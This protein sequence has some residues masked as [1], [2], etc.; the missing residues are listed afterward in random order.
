M[1]KKLKK[2]LIELI[3]IF[4]IVV[5]C[6]LNYTLFFNIINY[7]VKLTMPLIIGLSLAFIVN[8][9]MKAIE[10]KWFKV[11]KRKNKKLIRVLSLIISLILIFGI[12]SL[13]LF[14]VVPEV[15]DAVTSILKS[16]Y[17]IDWNHGIASKIENIYP[18]AKTY[19]KNINLENMVN[20][21]FGSPKDI[22][23][24]IVTFVTG[25]ASKIFMFFMGLIISIYI[26]V[27]K[28]N[29]ITT[30]KKVLY[31]FVK[32]KEAKEIENVFS[33]ANK[34]FSNFITGQCLDAL[35]TG[36]ELFIVLWLVRIP[37][38]LIIGVLFSVTALIPYIG[39]F[40]T[41]IIG[42]LLVAVV[43]PIYA[44]WYF[45]IY[46][47]IQQ[48]DNNYTYPKIVGNAVGLPP[49]LALVA[50][51]IGGSISGF[52]GMIISIPLASVLYTLF[53]DYINK[54]LENKKKK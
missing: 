19:I 4:G 52:I 54:R 50:V 39:G 25:M 21:T 47:I 45:I 28:E 30:T 18:N 22:V 31:A 13:I 20:T 6:V 16:I 8:V 10:E 44:L 53:K 42:A 41:L 49:L 40:I 17:N 48:F 35:L 36:F 51:L 43:N 32:E 11:N 23:N 33:L 37:Y 24:T 29:L 46:T 9:P 26:L 2:E 5:W 14:L 12:L 3:I 38:A 7:I 27:D 1:D 15:F 34:T